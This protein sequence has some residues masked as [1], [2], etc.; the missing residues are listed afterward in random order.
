[1]PKVL[2]ETQVRVRDVEPGDWLV[3]EGQI[4]RKLG[5]FGPQNDT[6]TIVFQ[7]GGAADLPANQK[8]TILR[9]ADA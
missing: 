9:G 5:P 4:K 7:G 2:T 3:A 8:L 6:Y 1:M